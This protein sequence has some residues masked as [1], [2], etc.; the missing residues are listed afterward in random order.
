MLTTFYSYG[1]VGT[2][3]QGEIIQGLG[4]ERKSEQPDVEAFAEAVARH[5]QRKG[6]SL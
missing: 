5:L 1:Q 3:R 6:E 2:R 4:G